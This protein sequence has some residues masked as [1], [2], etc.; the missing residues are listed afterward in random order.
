VRRLGAAPATRQ[1]GER[2]VRPASRTRPATFELED[3]RIR[4]R[5]SN[6]SWRGM[7]VWRQFAVVSGRRTN[8]AVLKLSE[9]KS[10]GRMAKLELADS[11]ANNYTLVA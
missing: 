10:R 9:S 1:R 11:E 3:V 6:C 2:H 8:E 5:A 4:K 7:A